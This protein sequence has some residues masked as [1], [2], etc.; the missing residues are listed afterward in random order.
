MENIEE[1]TKLTSEENAIL[2]RSL[3]RFRKDAHRRKSY[4]YAMV[5]AIC[6]IYFIG[7]QSILPVAKDV[8]SDVNVKD[9]IERLS[10]EPIPED[11]TIYFLR[12]E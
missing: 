1:C 5:A 4:R 6:F 11:V 8:R 7:I 3:E 10:Y 12:L 9:I 2:T